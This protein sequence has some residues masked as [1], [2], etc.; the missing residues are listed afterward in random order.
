MYDVNITSLRLFGSVNFCICCIRSDKLLVTL[1]L[2]FSEKW[3]LYKN[4]P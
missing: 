2:G 3:H 4:V 1:T